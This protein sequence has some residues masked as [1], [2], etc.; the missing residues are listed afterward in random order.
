MLASTEGM[1]FKSMRAEK[2][3]RTPKKVKAPKKPRRK[4]QEPLGDTIS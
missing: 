4:A 2:R 3:E 1:M